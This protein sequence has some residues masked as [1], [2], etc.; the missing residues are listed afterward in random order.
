MASELVEVPDGGKGGE[1]QLTRAHRILLAAWPFLFLALVLSW[2]ASIPA[3]YRQQLVEPSADV[4]FETTAEVAT[5]RDAAGLSP[6][7]YAFYQV[8]VNLLGGTVLFIPISLII[9]LYRRED[10]GALIM[11]TLF[12]LI[13]TGG[14]IFQ[15]L[16]VIDYQWPALRPLMLISQFISTVCI[17][18]LFYVFPDGR[19]VPRWTRLFLLLFAVFYGLTI[20]REGFAD[21]LFNIIAGVF[22]IV[23]FVGSQIYRYRRVSGPIEREQIKWAMIGLM[24]WPF[25]WILMALMRTLLVTG[26]PEETLRL[27][28]L[29]NLFLWTPLFNLMPIGIGIAILRYRLYDIDVIIRRTTSY[30]VITGLLALVY[31]GSIVALQR[32]LTPLTGESDIAVVLSTLLIAALFLPLRRRVQN[33]ID[34]RFY[35]RKYNAEKTLQ[36]FAAT[37]RDEADLDKLTAELLRVIQETMEPEHVSIWLKP[38]EQREDVKQPV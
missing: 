36:D 10:R 7:G 30:A 31:F 14:G 9:Y 28:M 29:L 25:V 27:L 24:A 13:G 1:A 16:D 2:A 5:A 11:A 3:Y 19:F 37:V 34:R 8:L 32:L 35:R 12:L 15:P 4:I 20:V 23:T 22:F 33:V 38:V 26:D 18:A 21:S 6:E 17:T